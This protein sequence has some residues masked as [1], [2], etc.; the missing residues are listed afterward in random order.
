MSLSSD[1]SIVAAGGPEDGTVF[2]DGIGATWLFRKDGSEGYTQL[3]PKLVGTHYIG[4]SLQ[5]MS[6][7]E[8]LMV[9]MIS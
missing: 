5:G 7:L 1:G 2:T 8:L 6:Y 4:Y 9:R 3:G